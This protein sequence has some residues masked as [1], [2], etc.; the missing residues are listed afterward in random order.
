MLVIL[1]QNWSI[2]A[3]FATKIQRNWLFL[4]DCFLAKFP[5]KISREIGQFLS[6][7]WLFSR[8]IGQFFHEF[9]PEIPAK[10]CFF[11]AKY[12]KPCVNNE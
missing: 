11:S 10:S 5:P 6:E 8:E 2:L 3:K 12:Q 7:F 1:T 4:T 9:A